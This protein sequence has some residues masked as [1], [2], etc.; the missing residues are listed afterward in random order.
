MKSLSKTFIAATLLLASATP[1]FAGESQ[2]EARKLREAG[3]ILPLEQILEKA[4]REQPGRVVETEL[5]KKSGRHVY[6]I[7]IVDEK[8]VVHELKYDAKTGEL[9][10]AK[11]EK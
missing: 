4:K 11:R 8:D 9:L 6:E 10:K 2:D 3:D 7:K 5:E 1:G